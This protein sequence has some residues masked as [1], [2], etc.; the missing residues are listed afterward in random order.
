[1]N[2]T[3]R[4]LTLGLVCFAGLFAF[5]PESASARPTPTQSYGRQ[6]YGNWNYQN[7]YYVRTYYYQPYS[8]YNGYHGDD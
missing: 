8:G 4:Q 2:T 6:Y 3:I 5:A 1:M 7:S